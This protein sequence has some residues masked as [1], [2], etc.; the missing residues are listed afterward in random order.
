MFRTERYDI[1]GSA[2]LQ[3][4]THTHVL[5][6]DRHCKESGSTLNTLQARYSVVY[7]RYYGVP[8]VSWS[9]SLYVR[10]YIHTYQV[11]INRKKDQYGHR[12]CWVST[13]IKNVGCAKHTHATTVSKIFRKYCLWRYGREEGVYTIYP[14]VPLRRIC[15]LGRAALCPT[16][17]WG[18]FKYVL[19]TQSNQQPLRVNQDC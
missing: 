18:T 1:A 2:F 3:H 7:V 12:V 4:R 13:D 10:T 6:T 11:S 16:K 19:L 9:Q 15:Q 8:I 5:C 14:H 17:T